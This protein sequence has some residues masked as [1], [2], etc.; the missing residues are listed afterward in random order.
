VPGIRAESEAQAV[1]KK[2]VMEKQEK[3]AWQQGRILPAGKRWFRKTFLSTPG[4]M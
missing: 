4:P 1:L 3:L 2:V